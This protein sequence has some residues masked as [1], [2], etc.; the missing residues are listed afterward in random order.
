MSDTNLIGVLSMPYELAMEGDLAR[1]QFHARA[2]AAADR[3]V[4]DG[5]RIEMLVDELSKADKIINAMLNSLTLD[6]K[7]KLASNLEE[8]GISLDG[9]TRANERRNLLKAFS[10]T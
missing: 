8:S 4:V 3:I 10:A 5:K 7:S 6:Q 2:Q 9:M 1:I